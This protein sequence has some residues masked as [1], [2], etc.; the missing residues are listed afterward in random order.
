MSTLVLFRSVVPVCVSHAGHSSKMAPSI[1]VPFEE[2]THVGPGT[3]I[4][5]GYQMV[6]KRSQRKGNFR[7]DEAIARL[8]ACCAEPMAAGKCI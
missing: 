4:L 6:I 5:D 2:R 1:E 7:G 3:R 8:F